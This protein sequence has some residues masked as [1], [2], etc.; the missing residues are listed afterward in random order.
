MGGPH[1]CDGD[2]TLDISTCPGVGLPPLG[3]EESGQAFQRVL[4]LDSH[5]VIYYSK[6]GGGVAVAI[7][8]RPV[9]YVSP[10]AKFSLVSSVRR[11]PNL[12]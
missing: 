10:H 5:H 12:Y 6:E 1:H 3:G 4:R 2:P 8:M 9:T 11:T 7:Y